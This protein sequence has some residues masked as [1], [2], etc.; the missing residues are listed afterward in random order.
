MRY[1]LIIMLAIVVF[2]AG[3][4]GISGAQAG[5]PPAFGVTVVNP[6]EKP[7]PVTVTNSMSV[8]NAVQV[9]NAEGTALK[10]EAAP[11]MLD[12]SGNTVKV[13]SSATSPLYVENVDAGHTGTS[14]NLTASFNMPTSVGEAF[15]ILKTNTAHPVEFKVPADKWLRVKNVGFV[16]ECNTG[17]YFT[18]ITLESDE[19]QGWLYYLVAPVPQGAFGVV[20]TVAASQDCDL[21]VGPSGT[22]AMRV[23]RRLPLASPSVGEMH[24][25]G[26]LVDAP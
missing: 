21:Y 9:T 7:V 24:I 17:D 5:T 3:A 12:P 14:V 23:V 8:T 18:R 15:A 4:L 2:V 10:V 6:L 22:L 25:S 19:P 13:D 1:R 11:V 16:A 20:Q 26:L